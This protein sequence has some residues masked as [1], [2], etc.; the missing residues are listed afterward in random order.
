MAYEVNK[1]DG[2]ILLNIQEGEIDT[3]Y[4][5][6]L[7][8]KNYLGYGELIAENFVKLLENFNSN[9]EPTNPIVG[10]I[11]YK[12]TDVIGEPKQINVYQGGGV[13]KPVGHLFVGAEPS[14]VKRAKGDMWFDT[15]NQGVFM[16]DGAS[17]IQLNNIFGVPGLETGVVIN[18]TIKD[19]NYNAATPNLYIHKAIKLKVNGILVAIVSSDADYTPHASENLQSFCGASANGAD[20]NLGT[21]DYNQTGVIGKGLNLNS[22]SDFKLRG[23]AIEAEFADVAEIYVGD[24]TYEPG[25]LVALG[26]VNEVTST[27]FDGDPGIFGVVSTRPAYLLNARRKRELHALPIAVAGRIPT[28]VTGPIAKGD[29]LVASDTPGVARKATKEDPLF[30]IIGRSLEDFNG[31]DI[32]LIEA[33]VGVR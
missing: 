26:G 19:S 10:Q 14:L 17:F 7:L 21:G 30:S 31:K 16:W 13:W 33:T 28:K 15:A 18:E 27:M 22:S 1:T 25:T 2:T 29:R 20:A 32:G 3:T 6:N 12:N 8:G 5:L 4:G 24:A 9:D 11:W 23:V